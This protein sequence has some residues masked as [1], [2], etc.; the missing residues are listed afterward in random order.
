MFWLYFQ[1]FF[2][3]VILL[4]SETWYCNNNIEKYFII[5]FTALLILDYIIQLFPTPRF[6]IPAACFA[7]LTLTIGHVNDIHAHFEEVN[8]FTGR[9]QSQEAEDGRCYGGVARMYTLIEELSNTRTNW[10]LL[11]AGDYYQVNVVKS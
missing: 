7:E 1:H 3:L 4:S 8:V 11:N 2:C 9:C 10:M 6:L 5:K